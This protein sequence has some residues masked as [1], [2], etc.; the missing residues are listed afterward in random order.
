MVA[1]INNITATT[2]FHS[3]QEQAVYHHSSSN[4][5]SPNT[6]QINKDDLLFLEVFTELF[7]Y[8]LDNILQ[9]IQ[10]YK[11][12][13]I[14]FNDPV[15]AEKKGLLFNLIN[16]SYTNNVHLINEMKNKLVS[17]LLNNI[18]FLNRPKSNWNMSE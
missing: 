3:K 17:S 8:E 11:F 15:Y 10:L 14:A 18:T 7:K 5:Y 12:N 4:V 2:M 16:S 6:P 13:N 9:S 1:S